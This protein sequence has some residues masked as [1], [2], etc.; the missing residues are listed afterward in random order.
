MRGMHASGDVCI[1][2]K[3]TL[4]YVIELPLPAEEEAQEQQWQEHTGRQRLVP[5]DRV[6][7]EGH[8]G[9]QE[10][11]ASAWHLTPSKTP[12]AAYIRG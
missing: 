4:G 11:A 9:L 8:L 3:L 7:N 2:H 5:E 10:G 6:A 12:A 1:W